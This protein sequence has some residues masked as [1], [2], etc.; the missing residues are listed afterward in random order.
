MK[1]HFLPNLVIFIVC[2][3]ILAGCLILAPPKNGSS[4]VQIGGIPLPIICTFRSLTGIPCPGC[5]LLRSMVYAMHGEV[6]KS[7]AHHRLGLITLVY[8]G[9]QFLFRL[10]VLLFPMLAIRFSRFDSYLNRG[11]ILLA[12]LFGINWLVTLIA[13]F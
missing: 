1:S 9:L 13:F 11:V 5:G 12:L 6:K 3:G 8:V 10:A 7:L 2:F 4:C